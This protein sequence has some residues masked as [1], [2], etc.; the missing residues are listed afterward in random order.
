VDAVVDVSNRLTLDA[1][2]ARAFF[3][4]TTGNLQAAAHAAGAR[5][6]VVLSIVCVDRVERNAHY[7]GK[8]AQ[9]QVALAGPVPAS[10]LRATQ[11]HA[12]AARAGGGTRRGQE[13]VI[14]PL[15]LQPVALADV[16]DVLVEVALGEPLRGMRELAGPETQDLV[17][18]A[19]RT[20][21]AR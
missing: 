6:L 8:R 12:F 14:A 18:M 4:A 5:H 20:L 9:E 11:F 3:A 16:A 17:D 21:A 1:D 10:I 19:R 2:K 7:A 13:A 15:L